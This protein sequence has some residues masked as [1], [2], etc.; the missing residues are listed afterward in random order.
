MDQVGHL[1]GML[2]I[3]VDVESQ[4]NPQRFTV[5]LDFPGLL[6]TTDLQDLEGPLVTLVTG[7]MVVPTDPKEVPVNQVPLDLVDQLA[8][9]EHMALLEVQGVMET[10]GL[11]ELL[12]HLE[13]KGFVD[14]VDLKEIKESKEPLEA[15]DQL[16]L[17]DYLGTRDRL[18]LPDSPET[19]DTKALKV[20][21]A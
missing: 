7:E 11:Q 2:N 12:D 10:L 9:P 17:L 16:D 14:Y 15:G 5:F 6:A 20:T 21:K 19:K 1:H 8:T 18:D 13:P 4:F 3:F